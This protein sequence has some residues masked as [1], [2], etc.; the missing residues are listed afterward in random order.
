MIILSNLLLKTYFRHS[1]YNTV[2]YLSIC[3]EG[4]LNNFIYN[5]LGVEMISDAKVEMNFNAEMSMS[6]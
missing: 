2:H 5:R 6:R 4:F 3:N 1:K